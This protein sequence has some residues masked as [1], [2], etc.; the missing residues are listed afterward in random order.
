MKTFR[1][2]PFATDLLF[3]MNNFNVQTSYLEL[4]SHLD[5]IT[6]NEFSDL[7]GSGPMVKTMH[8]HCWGMGSIPGQGNR[9]SCMP[10][11]LAKEI[12]F[13]LA[14]AAHILKKLSSKEKFRK[15]Q[16]NKLLQIT[17]FVIMSGK[18]PA[19]NRRDHL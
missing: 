18:E 9:R 12:K 15:Q 1:N 5:L 11:S 4:E 17:H 3:L 14:S 2:R 6:Q 10:C 7:L 19:Y 13:V 8:F 16:W